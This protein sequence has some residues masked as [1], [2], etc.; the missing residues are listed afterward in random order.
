MPNNIPDLTAKG[1]TQGDSWPIPTDLWADS[2]EVQTDTGMVL[3]LAG[4]APDPAKPEREGGAAR[5]TP[6]T[7]TADERRAD[8]LDAVRAIP[9]RTTTQV[10][11]AAGIPLATA[12][13]YLKKMEA[14]GILE[15]SKGSRGKTTFWFPK[16]T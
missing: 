12:D 13:R 7:T 4:A 1:V 15:T 5:R 14:E 6:S 10:A 9:G 8:L 3:D 2:W 11:D 16:A